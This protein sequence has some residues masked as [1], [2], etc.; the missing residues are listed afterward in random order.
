MEFNDR[1]HREQSK[2]DRVICKLVNCI[3]QAGI[4]VCAVQ[5]IRG[6]HHHDITMTLP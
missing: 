2:K 6:L 4:E 1:L 5:F 3:K